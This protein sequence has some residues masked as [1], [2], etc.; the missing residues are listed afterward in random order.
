VRPPL[1]LRLRRAQRAAAAAAAAAPQPPH[2]RRRAAAAGISASSCRDHRRYVLHVYR[3][4]PLAVP[5]VLPPL[6]AVYGAQRERR[7]GVHAA[8]DRPLLP[9]LGLLVGAAFVAARVDGCSGAGADG[10]EQGGGAAGAGRGHQLA[11]SRP[12]PRLHGA[13]LKGEGGEV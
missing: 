11:P 3:P 1:Q 5:H 6:R 9:L 13:Q 10:G 8:L 4:Q 12:T 2:A 7:A